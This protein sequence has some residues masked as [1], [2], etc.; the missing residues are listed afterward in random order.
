[1]GVRSIGKDRA[2]RHTT[3]NEATTNGVRVHPRG[4][5]GVLTVV[6]VVRTVVGVVQG[7]G[8]ALL[9]VLS[10]KVVITIVLT[11]PTLQSIVVSARVQLPAIFVIGRDIRPIE[12][13]FL[14]RW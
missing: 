4:I 14:K 6:G 8:V 5:V 7:S 11:D 10:P 12:L 3:V 1:M 13:L 2:A 9:V